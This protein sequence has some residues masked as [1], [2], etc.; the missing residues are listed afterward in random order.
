[1]VNIEM[2]QCVARGGALE[3]TV[4]TGK[5]AREAKT[6]ILLEQAAAGRDG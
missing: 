3:I 4:A 2:L 5:K 1:M 6:Y